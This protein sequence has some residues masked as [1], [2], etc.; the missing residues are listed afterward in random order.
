MDPVFTL[1]YSEY[2]VVERIVEYLGKK[3]GFSVY[4]PSSRQEKNVDFLVHSAINNKSLRFQ[5]KSSRS[6]VRD[7]PRSLEKGHLT[8]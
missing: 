4:V 7:D 6:Y 2:A 1:P 5:V 3:E 8:T